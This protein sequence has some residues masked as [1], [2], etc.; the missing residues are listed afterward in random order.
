M[1]RAA[2]AIAVALGLLLPA[3]ADA[4]TPPGDRPANNALIAQIVPI[5]YRFWEDRDVHPCPRAQLDLR[6]ADDLSD[7]KPWQRAYGRGQLGGCKVWLLTSLVA[8]AQGRRPGNDWATYLCRTATI[9]VG[10][11]AG[12]D[13]DYGSDGVMD[14]SADFTHGTPFACRQWSARAR[15]ARRA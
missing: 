6:L 1:L 15:H 14:P 3:A 2:L 13:D 11:T 8:S 5:V 4:W 9:E 7:G 10:H 12:L